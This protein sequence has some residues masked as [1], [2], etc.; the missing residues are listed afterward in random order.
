MSGHWIEIPDADA[1][2]DGQFR[3]VPVDGIEGAGILVA[4]CE[5][6]LRAVED[7]CSHDDG[8]LGDGAVEGCEIICPR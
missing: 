8:P 2:E 6:E 4:R 5:G 7:R 1:L 3:T